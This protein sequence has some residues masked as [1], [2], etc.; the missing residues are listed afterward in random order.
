[1]R[2]KINF[3][4]ATLLSLKPPAPGKRLVVWDT[5][6]Q[7]LQC[8]V[9]GKGVITFSLYRRVKNGRPIRVTLGKLGDMTVEQAREQ[10][11]LINAAIV[12]GVDPV[13]VRTAHRDELT[14]SELYDDYMENYAKPNKKSWKL[15]T[16]RYSLYLKEPLG[17]KK[18]S[19]ITRNDLA[20]LHKKITRIPS[21]KGD[22][23]AVS[24]RK[25][26]A[27]RVMALIGLVF[28]W[29]IKTGQCV[30]NPTRN[31]DL[32]PEKSRD[33]FLQP[34]ELARFFDAVKDEK[35]IN[36]R[37]YVLLSLYTG[38][39]Q[40]NI[41][42]MR[43]EEI[44]FSQQIWR[45]PMTKNGESVIVPLIEEAI[46]ILLERKNNDS[47][48]VFPSNRKTG[49][50]R[51]SREGWH[52]ILKRAGIKNLHPHDLRRTMGSWQAITGSS[53][54]VIGKSLGHKSQA[55][56]AIY[57]RLHLDPVRKSMESATAAML[58]AAQ[59]NTFNHRKK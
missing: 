41:L 52:K 39:R 33:R 43:W 23:R 8:R 24:G 20:A 11:T 37:D 14:F 18:L 44:S 45:I 13:K 36:L 47:E 34:E 56:T 40:T 9:S 19:Q 58:M 51:V 48:F 55:A 10:A 31:I 54:A 3:T 46:A 53:L 16:G 1:M 2:K 12:Q 57:A 28:K 50:M 38:A 35:D 42:S 17:K 4:K 21:A 7:G 15:E 29:G 22:N 30:E 59:N 26:T 27:N 5:K 25:V 6:I 32:F 49:Y